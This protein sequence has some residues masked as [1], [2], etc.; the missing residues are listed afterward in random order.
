MSWN[1]Q[2]REINRKVKL[3]KGQGGKEAVARQHAKG[4]LTIRER[5]DAVLD[6]KSFR[7]VGAGSGVAERD[8]DGKLTDFSPANFVLGFGKIDGRLCVVGGEDFTL[9]GGSP[10]EAGLRKSVYTEELACQYRV[11]LV[12]LHEGGGGSV[13]GTGS[14]TVGASVAMAPRF[15]SVA[16][17]MA[18]VPVASAA[19]RSVAGLPASRLVASHFDMFHALDSLRLAQ[20]L[21]RALGEVGKKLPVLLQFNVSGEDTKGGWAAWMQAQWQ[22]LLPEVEQILELPN[23]A[24]KGLMTM[25][26]LNSDIEQVR[27]YFR[28]LR[29]LRDFLADRFPGVVFGDLSMG[30]SSD[31][32]VAVEEGANFVRLGTVII[33]PRP[34]KDKF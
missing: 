33:G 21:D 4:R 18:K 3:A 30:T 32:G 23:L 10:N 8:E 29:T 13:A 9:K 27:P 17:A 24:I 2:V 22:G 5:V 25:P 34:P 14:K 16:R 12:R 7:E 19:V 1:K 20:K 28:R 6:K 26:P 31:Y 11:P 15:R